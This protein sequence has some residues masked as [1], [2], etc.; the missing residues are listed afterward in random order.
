MANEQNLIPA[1]KGEI[2]NPKGKTK[3]VKNWSTIVRQLLADEEFADK[4]LNK[5]PGWWDSLPNKNLGMAIAAA[6]MQNALAGNPK[7]AEWIRKTGFGDKLDITSDDR[8]IVPIAIYDLRPDNA[9]DNSN[10]DTDSEDQ[11]EAIGSDG[12]D[13]EPQV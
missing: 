11:P 2:R 7:A 10:D 3:G 4:I 5:K 13:T 9:N 8:P 6:M 12:G 1:R